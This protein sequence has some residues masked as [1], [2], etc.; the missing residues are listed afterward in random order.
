MTL[1]LV[2]VADEAYPLRAALS[3]LISAMAHQPADCLG[4]LAEVVRA[5][6]ESDTVMQ[7]V[8]TELEGFDEM[9]PEQQQALR[10]KI[11]RAEVVGNTRMR[12][13]RRLVR[14]V[15]RAQRAHI[16]P[17]RL[18]RPSRARR[19][20]RRGRARRTQTDAGGDGDGDGDDPTGV[21]DGS[22]GDDKRSRFEAC[23]LAT[24]RPGRP[25][26]QTST[27]R[28]G[29]RATSVRNSSTAGEDHISWPPGLCRVFAA[30]LPRPPSWGPLRAAH[31]GGRRG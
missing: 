22:T 15:M 10:L 8:L 28:F 24:V 18:R 20:P 11:A 13:C 21:G 31:G 26:D 2:L 3:G 1:R 14:K 9:G 4:Q 12:A 17:P 7:A 19:A 29:A 6:D 23:G 25:G 5:L 30:R 27:A 16:G